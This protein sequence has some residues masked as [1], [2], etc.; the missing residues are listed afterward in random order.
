MDNYTLLRNRLNYLGGGAE[1]RIIK[2]KEK[3][4]LSAL[5][6]SY[7]S[8]VITKDEI[9]HKV[10]INPDR[11]KMDYDDKILSAPFSI[12][13]KVGDVFH[14]DATNTDWIIYSQQF[15][16]D[17]YF[18]GAI[19]NCRYKIKW[20]DEFG[21]EKD[22]FAAVIG[23]QETKIVSDLRKGISYDMPNNS[24]TILIPANDDTKKVFTRYYKIMMDGK[25]WEVQVVDS[26]STPG[27]LQL[28]VLEHYK[29]KD[30]D[31]EDFIGGKLLSPLKIE[32]SLDFPLINIGQNFDLWT[33]IY[34]GS[35]IL[36]NSAIYSV[37]SGN[38]L[39]TD[40]KIVISDENPVVINLSIPDLEYTGTYTVSASAIPVASTV[41][42]IDGPLSIKPYGETIYSIKKYIDGSLSTPTGSWSIIGF[43]AE[44]T[45]QNSDSATVSWTTSKRGSVTLK[46]IDGL[47][48][49]E[50]E[51]VILSLF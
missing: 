13:F 11:L 18:R 32:S 19:R 49:V 12:G 3:S 28:V 43:G 6:D 16:E 50:Q 22:A 10:L 9:K 29:N 39:I 34:R 26:I 46:Y 40:S 14:W 8:A 30:Q 31:T 38:G 17:A 1:S 44:I 42:I 23:P 5:V 37:V 33:K 36:H 48:S 25:A 35:E 51:I 45:S 20:L 27:V 2:D 15:T 7:Q 41:M 21:I 47:D 4:F 24:L